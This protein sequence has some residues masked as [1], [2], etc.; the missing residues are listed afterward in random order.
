MMTD[1]RPPPIGATVID[2]TVTGKHLIGGMMTARAIASAACSIASGRKMATKS[3]ETTTLSSATVG[4]ASCRAIRHWRSPLAGPLPTVTVCLDACWIVAD[5]DGSR[6]TNLY[7]S[8]Y[9]TAIT[10]RSSCRMRA[11]T[12]CR[13][14][15]GRS[16]LHLGQ[17]A[18]EPCFVEF[19]PRLA[20]EH[21]AQGPR[22]RRDLDRAA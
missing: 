12:R 22:E 21:A 17:P 8:T 19:E 9:S 11:A 15:L 16:V 6:G 2:E 13:G 5:F 1:A 10:V 7:V 3:R 18:R 4:L 14:Q 20:V